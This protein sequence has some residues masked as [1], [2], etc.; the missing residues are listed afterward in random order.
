MGGA[1]RMLTLVQHLTDFAHVGQVEMTWEL[2][3]LDTCVQEALKTRGLRPEESGAE[4]IDG[5]LPEVIGDRALLIQLYQNLIG[6]AIKFAGQTRPIIRLTAERRE[7]GWLLGVRDNGIG[8]DPMHAKRIF[9]PFKRLHSR[10]QYEGSGLEL[11][12][13]RRIVRRHGGEIWVEPEVDQGAYIK[14][15]LPDVKC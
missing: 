2:L 1:Q 3:A 14:F 10:S 15:T 8:I 7:E 12:V 6:N 11:A 9:D 4:V 5:G 13:C